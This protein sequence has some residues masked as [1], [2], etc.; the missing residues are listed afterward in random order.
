MTFRPA[1]LV[2]LG[3]F[4]PLP[5]AATDRLPLSA[6]MLV[7][8]LHASPDPHV[9][10]IRHVGHIDH[11]GAEWTATLATYLTVGPLGE[12]GPFG[13]R[14]RRAVAGDALLGLNLPTQRF[15]YGQPGHRAPH[16]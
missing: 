4:A 2:F 15:L 10:M 8:T 5:Y 12:S 1:R 6:L 11:C 13:C 9:S 14:S 3:A 16:R 7:V